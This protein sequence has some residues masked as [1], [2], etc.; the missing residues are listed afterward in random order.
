MIWFPV[1]YTKEAKRLG[2]L[3]GPLIVAQLSQ[4]GMGVI[5]VVIAGRYGAVD[6]AGVG[7]GSSLFWPLTLL[8][9]GTLMAVTPTVAQLHGG[10]RTTETGPVVRQALWMAFILALL[11]FTV[12]QNVEPFFRWVNVDPAAIPIASQYLADLSYGVFAMLGYYV[13]KNLCEGLGFTLPSMVILL[14]AL[15]IKIPLTYV[16]VFGYGE[17][18]GLGGIGCGRAN[19]VIMWFQLICIVIA[20]QI[21]RIRLSR[22]FQKIEWPH[23]ST[24]F[25]LAKLGLPMGLT[26]FVEV[27]FF[28]VV[29]LLVGKLGVN[30]VASHQIA[31]SVGGLGFMI[32]LALGMA[33]TIRVGTNI[34]A[35][36]F[37]A[38]RRSVVVAMISSISV[39]LVIA[40]I[41]LLTRHQIVQLYSTNSEVVLLAAH[42][43][44]FCAIFQLFD[45]SQVTAVGSL[46]GA[47]DAKVPMLLAT[48]SYW[49]IGMPIG[50][51]LTFGG[52]GFTG[53]GVVGFWYGMI[54]GLACASLLLVLRLRWVTNNLSILS[55]RFARLQQTRK[56]L[57]ID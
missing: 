9:T 7:L 2:I 12:L 34:G 19:A 39:G 56:T 6:L 29:T 23:F 30:A 31:M 14:F 48:I 46:R 49:L 8:L 16:L 11:I 15:A 55:A 4:M 45:S 28:S 54:I 1:S 27:S 44:L 43:L 51:V 40:T 38:A 36:R 21:T 18:E 37:H 53:L 52:F 24:I 26:I 35:K 50:I 20:I 5:D 13:L 17:F 10:N 57:P 33:S 3:A 47:K 42:L 41:L 22:V 25:S 32:P